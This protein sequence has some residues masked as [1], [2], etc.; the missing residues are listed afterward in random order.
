[1]DSI[2]KIVLSQSSISLVKLCY[3][4]ELKHSSGVDTSNLAAKLI[5]LL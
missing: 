5:L 1:M 2:L 3:Q 4:K